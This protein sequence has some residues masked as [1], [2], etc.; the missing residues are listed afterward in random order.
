MSDPATPA[1]EQLIKKAANAF[2]LRGGLKNQSGSLLLYPTRLV[3]VAR[4]NLTAGMFGLIGG[5]IASRGKAEKR[6]AAGG[7][8]VTSIPLAS[9][10][11]VTKGSQAL[12]K[13]VL[14]V[15][16]SDGT[17]LRFGVKYDDWSPAICQ[18]VAA[19]GRAVTPAEDGFTFA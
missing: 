10:S 4:S 14:V 5:L 8:G 15:H 1:Q 19:A 12:N 13:N 2:L 3:H 9:L 16:E 7:K 11:G 18:A 6:A 17:E